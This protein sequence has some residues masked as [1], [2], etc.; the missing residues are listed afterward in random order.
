V[1]RTGPL[2]AIALNFEALDAAG[3]DVTE[4]PRDDD[5]ARRL[6]WCGIYEKLMFLWFHERSQ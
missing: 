1:I 6:N 5:I 4:R 3:V 2:R